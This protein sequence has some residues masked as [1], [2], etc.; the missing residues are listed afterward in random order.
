MSPQSPIET[1][2]SQ[3]LSHTHI[4]AQRCRWTPSFPP[5][6]CP[7]ILLANCVKK[8]VHYAKRT[9]QTS[10]ASTRSATGWRPDR[11]ALGTSNGLRVAL[12]PQ[13]RRAIGKAG[14]SCCNCPIYPTPPSLPSFIHQPIYPSIHCFHIHP[15]SPS[16]PPRTLFFS[17]TSNVWCLA[18]GQAWRLVGAARRPHPVGT[19]PVEQ[20]SLLW[21]LSSNNCTGWTLYRRHGL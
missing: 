7:S 13:R 1:T 10:L 9:T 2:L 20:A 17:S 4:H 11:L 19:A 18:N 15:P 5:E 8:C 3:S 21:L 6:Q 16:L 12:T 14:V